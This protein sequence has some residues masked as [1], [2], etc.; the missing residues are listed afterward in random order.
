MDRTRSLPMR[1]GDRDDE[2]RGTPK[3][4]DRKVFSNQTIIY[5]QSIYNPTT[6]RTVYRVSRQDLAVDNSQISSQK[7]DIEGYFFR[8]KVSTPIEIG[9]NRQ[10][11]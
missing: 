11:G 3:I 1:P 4:S 9:V 2:H 7:V 10:R 8:Y 6:T 5:I